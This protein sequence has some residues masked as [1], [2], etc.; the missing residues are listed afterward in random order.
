LLVRE[1]GSAGL[2]ATGA[3]QLSIISYTTRSES[4]E[5]DRS[6]VSLVPSCLF[7]V[8]PCQC[9]DEVPSTLAF[10]GAWSGV[11]KDLYGIGIQSSGLHPLE[12]S[13]IARLT[14]RSSTC[15]SDFIQD[16]NPQE[17]VQ[18][19]GEDNAI[20]GEGY[21]TMH[22]SASATQLKHET[23]WHLSICGHES[24]LER[25]V[26]L[27]CGFSGSSARVSFSLVWMISD[28]SL[29]LTTHFPPHVRYFLL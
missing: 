4:S 19:C 17:L 2:K 21:P 22:R 29:L 16:A 14:R 18:H 3:V 7:S 1:S 13:R 12:S 15:L 8:G 6:S 9:D 10:R 28:R 5:N 11:G 27:D 23:I 25:I 26:P 20:V 24:A